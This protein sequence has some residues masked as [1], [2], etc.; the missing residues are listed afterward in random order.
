MLNA[1]LLFAVLAQAP[2][3]AGSLKLSG[4]HPTYGVLGPARADPRYLPGDAV[5][6]EFEIDGISVAAD[7]KVLYSM[8]LEAADSKG[9]VL[10]RQNPTDQESLAT[11][12]GKSVLAFARLDIG[13]EHPAGDYT[14]KVGITDRVTKQ[15]QS[16]TQKYQV[17]PANLGVVQVRLSSDAE[18][19]VPVGLIGAGQP[20]W[21]N[22][23]TVG[24]ARDKAKSQPN[25]QFEFRVLDEAG[26]PVLT[27][28]DT[29]AINQDV[30]ANEKLLGAQFHI[31]VNR[32]GKFV[33]ELKVTDKVSGKTAVV[34]LPLLVYPRR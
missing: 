28:P 18:G 17:L 12:G 2:G 31:S 32:D 25:L 33:A 20:I 3:Q 29:G 26:K 21:V 9:K 15:S 11:L 24:F 5:F 7:G 8:S 22:F 14:V 13:P 1:L 6:L 4:V 27:K 19:A 30:P 23:A 16:F 10:Y 34:A